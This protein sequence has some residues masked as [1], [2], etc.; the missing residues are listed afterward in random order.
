MGQIKGCQGTW[1]ETM[2]IRGTFSYLELTRFELNHLVTQLE[3][4]QQELSIRLDEALKIQ[5]SLFDDQGLAQ[6]VDEALRK[7]F[8]LE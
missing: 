3:I 8:W 4:E 6:T 2:N 7:G 1:F 5:N